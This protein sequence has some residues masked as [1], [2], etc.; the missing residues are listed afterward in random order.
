MTAPVPS[1]TQACTI[2][3]A[4]SKATILDSV[5]VDLPSCSGT[6]RCRVGHDRVPFVQ[7]REG[8]SHHPEVRASFVNW[9]P[10]PEVRAS[11]VNWL[12]HPE[13][14]GVSRASKERKPVAQDE[15]RASKE[16]KPVAQD[17]GR[18]SKERK[19]VAQ[20][21]GRASKERT[22][23]ARDVS[24]SHS[25]VDRKPPR[26]GRDFRAH[27]KGHFGAVIARSGET[28]DHR[29]NPAADLPELR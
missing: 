15:G 18:A 16:R 1:M 22:R 11:F 14:R 28:I 19:P 9:L 10:H 6:V 13:V 8:P 26:E 29:N 25:R 7:D 5:M 17:E 12:P 2:R 4:K 21:E 20:D 3:F 23:I 27:H 24:G